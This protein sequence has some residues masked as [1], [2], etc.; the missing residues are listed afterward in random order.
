MIDIQ[1]NF[2]QVIE[3]KGMSTQ[4][5]AEY[6]EQGITLSMTPYTVIAKSKEGV[7]VAKFSS[8][9]KAIKNIV[10]TAAAEILEL[11]KLAKDANSSVDLNAKAEAPMQKPDLAVY[12]PPMAPKFPKPIA[13][14]SMGLGASAMDML[15]NSAQKGGAVAGD[16]PVLS[17][18]SN[19]GAVYLRDAKGLYCRVKGSNEG[20]VYFL[21]ADFGS[22]KMAGR[23]LGG[24]LAIRFEAANM[25][26]Y[27]GLFTEMG[28]STVSK[29]YASV[30]VSIS[31]DLDARKMV[32]A[33]VGA[34]GVPPHSPLPNVALI[35]DMGV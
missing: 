30:H 31:K 29:G 4:P 1:T 10:P 7:T 14:K 35:K 27:I 25:A 13:P 20:S 18:A 2:L 33:M 9:G 26:P 11:L 16:Y 12:H 22:L 6:I 24:K 28:M 15:S 3:S 23:W 19:T 34:V 5:F 17:P 21:L 32:M 8:P